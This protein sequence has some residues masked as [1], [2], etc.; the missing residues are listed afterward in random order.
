MVI[1][2][3]IPYK[4]TGFF[5]L[6]FIAMNDMMLKILIVAAVISIVISMIF[7]DDNERPIAWVEGAAIL[8]A[9]L[10]VTTV[11]AWNDYEKEKEFMKL[12]D[13]SDSQNNVMAMRKG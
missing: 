5:K 9:V 13:Y 6:F 7:A 8:M 12:T 3:K 2:N 11:T 1:I 10:V 4:R